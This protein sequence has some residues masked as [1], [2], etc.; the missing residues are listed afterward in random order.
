[1][2]EGTHAVAAHLVG[3]RWRAD[4]SGRVKISI[5]GPR[6]GRTVASLPQVAAELS[7][8]TPLVESGL[9]VDGK[10]LAVKGGG[11]PTS[12]TIY[13]APAGDLAP[14]RHVAVAY[15]RTD[16]TGTARAWAFRT[17]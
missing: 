9:W 13:G 14:G 15:G 5:L 6:P 4:V 3:G 17:R 10:E 2:L 12:G 8:K 16:T 11:T 7:S 1:M